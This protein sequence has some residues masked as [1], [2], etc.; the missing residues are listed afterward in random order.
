MWKLGQAVEDNTKKPDY[1]Q[2]AE[3]IDAKSNSL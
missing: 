2:H 1:K 3:N